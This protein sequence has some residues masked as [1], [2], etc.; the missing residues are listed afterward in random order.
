MRVLFSGILFF[1]AG[2]FFILHK[3]YGAALLSIAV[4]ILIILGGIYFLYL[5]INHKANARYFLT[6]VFLFLL[7][8]FFI[9]SNIVLP[10]VG[11]MSMWPAFMLLFGIVLFIYSMC[12]RPRQINIL[13]PS[14]AIIIMAVIFIPFSFKIIT[15]SLFR[16][17]AAWWP[18]L[19]IVAGITLLTVYFVSCI[20]KT[21]K[22][23]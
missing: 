14:V 18:I 5:S 15:V 10:D 7:G 3:F 12:K 22:R 2:L 9:F 19:F 23:F 17:V 13:V 8:V 6:G 4:P 11:F 21:R 20:K 1:I 16:F